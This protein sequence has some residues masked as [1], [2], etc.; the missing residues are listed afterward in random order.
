MALSIP[1]IAASDD[2]LQVDIAKE[3]EYGEEGSV[4]S[5]GSPYVQIRSQRLQRQRVRNNIK[6]YR[7]QWPVTCLCW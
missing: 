4:V 7:T 3:L 1:L 5:L 2:K 6:L